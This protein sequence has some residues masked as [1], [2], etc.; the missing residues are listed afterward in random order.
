MRN[1]QGP[2]AHPVRRRK[3]S[4]SG[5]DAVH[6]VAGV[7]LIIAAVAVAHVSAKGIANLAHFNATIDAGF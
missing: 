3:P 1:T 2:W 4:R 7:L 5:L 6:M